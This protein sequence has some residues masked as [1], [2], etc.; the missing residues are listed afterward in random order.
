METAVKTEVEVI[1]IKVVVVLIKVV[2]VVIKG[3]WY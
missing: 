3:W 1:L 2:V